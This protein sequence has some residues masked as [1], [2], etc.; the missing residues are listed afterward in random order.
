[1]IGNAIGI[2]NIEIYRSFSEAK[3]FWKSLEEE[4]EG[5]IFQTYDWLENWYKHVGHHKDIQLCIVTVFNNNQKVEMILP[6]GIEK[7]LGSLKLFWLG[8]RLAEYNAPLCTSSFLEKLNK[9][10]FINIWNEIKQKLP[11][12]DVIHFVVQPTVVG[13]WPNPFLYLG[14]KYQEISY[15]AQLDENWETFFSRKR[16]SKKRGD[17]RR[18]LKRLEKIGPL[19][20][21]QAKTAQEIK[22]ITSY[23]IDLKRK[24]HRESGWYDFLEIEG[25]RNFYHQAANALIPKGKIHLSALICGDEIISAHWG[26]V[27]KNRFYILMPV[28]TGGKWRVYSAGRLLMEYLMEWSCN[29]GLEI[30]DFTLGEHDYKKDWS[31]IEMPVYQ[32]LEVNTFKGNLYILQNIVRKRI[33]KHPQL[34]EKVRRLVYRF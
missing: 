1:M 33:E 21:V 18:K 13:K 7:I 8:G 14:K 31:D 19:R 22:D 24:R 5:Y 16:N 2:S 11:T 9:T 29:I 17:S 23:M 4:A 30:F 25:Y 3:C 26:M 32:Y 12:F 28:H 6:L 20:F 15:A 27:W 10:L 34:A